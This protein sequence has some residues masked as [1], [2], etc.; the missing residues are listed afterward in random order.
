MIENQSTDT[1]VMKKNKRRC[2]NVRQL[3]LLPNWCLP[4]RCPGRMDI[5]FGKGFLVACNVVLEITGNASNLSTY[6]NTLSSSSQAGVSFGPFSCK[7]SISSS[8]T[9]TGSTCKT[10]ASGC[11]YVDQPFV[12][13]TRPHV[14]MNRIEVKA[15]QIIGWVSQ[16]VPALPRLAH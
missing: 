4:F 16:M 13:H 11:R 12:L 10:T 1:T 6:M 14:A 5:N 2:C 9:D 15:P 8:S 3:R 7:A